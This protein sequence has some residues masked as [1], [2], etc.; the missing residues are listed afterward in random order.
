MSDPPS[1]HVPRAPDGWAAGPDP[2]SWAWG[3]I[4]PIAT[5]FILA[6]G[7]GP[8]AQQTEARLCADARALY[9]RFDCA[10]R[11]IWGTFYRRD[12]PIYDEEVV[13]LF[14]SPGPEAPTDY[15]EFEVS[16]DGVLLDA[17]IHN[18]AGR[19]AGI[20][21]D[22]A[23]DADVTWLARRDD[24]DGRWLAILVVPWA[25]VADGPP[26]PVWRANLTRIERPRDGSPAEFSCWSPT[27]AD[28]ADFHR[29]E[30]FGTLILP[31][32]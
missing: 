11:D 4:A 9:L 22:F 25:W 15:F 1:L 30:R 29:P 14:L 18:P 32:M 3:E 17:R 26:P 24:V 6:D 28:P 10:D 21:P 16:P 20:Q 5:P 12:A 19:L 31:A 7:S 13:E 27:L 23:W 8:A 2:L